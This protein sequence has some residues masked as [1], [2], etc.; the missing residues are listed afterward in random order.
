[1]DQ[2]DALKSSLPRSMGSPSPNRP[3]PLREQS[4]ERADSSESGEKRGCRAADQ[5][6]TFQ[7]TSQTALKSSLSRSM[8]SPSPNRPGP[9]R[10]QSRERADSG[11]SDEKRECRAADQYITFQW[12]SQTALKS[13][14]P[15]SMGSPSPNRP[16]PLREQSSERA[17]SGESGEKRGCRAADQYITFQWTSQTALKSS[18][19]RSM[20]SPSPN[21]PGPLREQSRERADS[22]ESDEK[23]ECRVADQYITFQWTSQTALKSSL[24]R[25]MGSPSPNRP[26]PLRE[27]SSERA[28]SGESDEKRECRAADQYITFQWTSQTALKS[29]LSRSMGSPSPNR[30]GPLREQSSERA[31]SGESGEKRGCRAADQYITF[32]WTS[33]TALKSSLSRSMGSPSPNRPGP[34]REQSRERADSGE[35][36]EKRECRAA[37]QYITFQWTSQTALKSSLSR[38]M[39]SPSPNRPGPLREQSRERADSGESDEKRE[40]RAADQ[41]ITFQWTSQTALKSSLPRSMGS[42]SPNRPGPLREQSSERA[43][44]GESDEKRECRAADQYITFQWTSQTA[45]KSSLPRSMGSPSPNR[46][47]P[48]RE[49]SSERADSGESGEKRG[50]RAADQYITFQW[51]SQTAL[52]S[53]L[54]RSMAI[55]QVP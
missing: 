1:M 45:L 28:D 19:S 54:P 41:Y 2:P 3:G 7:W 37:D 43:D 49:Q 50:C 14:L 36:D 52:K 25:S 24:P 4:S 9:L 15:R 6:I 32:Q 44:S 48:L 29:S 47:G 40:C 16:G 39:G 51:T 17:D 23:R 8:G 35:S 53:S 27:Q 30:P 38:S 20:G 46:P 18:L 13:S 42:P 11:E 10:E 34:L 21:R 12:T 26:G 22:G 5:Y 33:Q 55:D 31:D